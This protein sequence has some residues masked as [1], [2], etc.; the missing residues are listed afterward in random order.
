MFSGI[1]ATP[2]GGV[3]GATDC[4]DER[5]QVQNTSDIRVRSTHMQCTNAAR[6]PQERRIT[7]RLH[8]IT[9]G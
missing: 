1:D 7:D 5:R 6:K 4:T 8:K 3:R 2:F 9:A